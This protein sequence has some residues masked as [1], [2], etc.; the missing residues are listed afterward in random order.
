M[1][2]Y[3]QASEA[4][5]LRMRQAISIRQAAWRLDVLSLRGAYGQSQ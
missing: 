3:P 2:L 5:A 4:T 1:S